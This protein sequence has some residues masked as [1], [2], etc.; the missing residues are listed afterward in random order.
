MSLDARRS[1]GYATTTR[2]S[3]APAG[4]AGINRDA[5]RRLVAS[6]VLTASSMA[7]T[8]SPAS[9]TTSGRDAPALCAPAGRTSSSAG[10]PRAAVGAS[11]A[12]RVTDSSTSSRRHGATRAAQP[13][14]RAF[15]TATLPD[16]DVVQRPDGIR[17]DQPA[18]DRRRHDRAY[19]DETALASMIE[20]ALARELCTI[21]DA[22]AR[23][24]AT[25]HARAPVGTRASCGS[26]PPGRPGAPAESEWER[27]VFD[28][29][30]G[31]GVR[32]T[33]P[34]ARRSPSRATAGRGST[35]RSPNCAG[36][37]RSTS[38]RSTA[39]SR[40]RLETTERDD[41]ADAV[42]WFVRR[43]P[44]CSSSTTSTARSTRPSPRRRRRTPCGERCRARVRP[45]IA[46][47]G[48]KH[49]DGVSRWS[50]SGWSRRSVL[51]G[52]SRGRR[53][54]GSRR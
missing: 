19:V 31:R 36:R 20:H 18:A 12:A 9:T 25:R 17:R 50:S 4:R 13:W 53:G 3:P 27:R 6:G 51:V 24:R 45:H 44:R 11:G 48:S 5:R 43:V 38:T 14:V 8:A 28:A 39:R 1:R 30:A 7:G 32:R 54:W 52:G 41:A 46:H 26:S 49:S 33:R 16:D 22:A 35:W 10:R 42:G 37:W 21:V 15:R 29:L 2:P 40:A 34:P 23:G 47:R